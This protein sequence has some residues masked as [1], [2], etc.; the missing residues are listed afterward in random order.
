[1]RT[2]LKAVARRNEEVQAI[3]ERMTAEYTDPGVFISLDQSAGD[4]KN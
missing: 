4:E 1:M 2:I 3:W